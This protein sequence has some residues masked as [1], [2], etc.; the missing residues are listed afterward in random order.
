MLSPS[1]DKQFDPEKERDLLLVYQKL[2]VHLPD[3]CTGTQKQPLDVLAE[4]LPNVEDLEVIEEQSPNDACEHRPRHESGEAGR[5]R[6]AKF[7]PVSVRLLP[8]KK[9]L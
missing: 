8:D 9:L 1:L 3:L 6:S 5:D 2:A 7:D 4:A